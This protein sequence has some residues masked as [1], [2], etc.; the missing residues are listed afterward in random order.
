MQKYM[1]PSAASRA[2]KVVDNPV[3][4]HRTS[5]ST[6]LKSVL[7]P[8]SVQRQL[9]DSIEEGCRE[10]LILRHLSSSPQLQLTTTR[11]THARGGDLTAE[12]SWTLQLT[13][14]S[15]QD[16]H[17]AHVLPTRRSRGWLI[18]ETRIPTLYGRSGP[19]CISLFLPGTYPRIWCQI[20]SSNWS[21][22]LAQI[23]FVEEN[24]KRFSHLRRSR[25]FAPDAV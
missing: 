25:D 22:N 8:T 7:Q 19:N 5:S 16:T 13:C 10:T 12:S 2:D 3:E 6:R 9:N 18:H 1:L 23:C 20:W 11:H 17:G 24:S 4:M 15:Q 21:R 14:R